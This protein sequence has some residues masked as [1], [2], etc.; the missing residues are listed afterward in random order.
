[1]IGARPATSAPTVCGM[2][3]WEYMTMTTTQQ[4]DIR[5]A[6]IE[7]YLA[8]GPNYEPV[9]IPIDQPVQGSVMLRQLDALGSEGWQLFDSER[10][11]RGNVAIRVFWLKRRGQ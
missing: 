9:M 7:V 5:Q 2:E 1:M 3:R 11:D 8:A 6:P 4:T 10:Q